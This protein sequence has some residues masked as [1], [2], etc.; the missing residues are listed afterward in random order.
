MGWVFLNQNSSMD[1]DEMVSLIVLFGDER[2]VQDGNTI[3]MFYKALHE[4]QL[5][6][7]LSLWQAGLLLVLF[8]DLPCPDSHT[9]YTSVY[10]STP[11][12]IWVVPSLKTDRQAVE[13]GLPCPALWGTFVPTILWS[14]QKGGGK[15]YKFFICLGLGYLIYWDI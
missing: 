15:F 13:A 5:T 3:L 11:R 8:E 10:T 14:Y 7:F 2:W 4:G 6:Q 1:K 9:A 12:R